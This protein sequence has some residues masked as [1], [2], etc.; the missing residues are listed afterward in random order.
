MFEIRDVPGSRAVAHELD[1]ATLID[2]TWATP[3]FFDAH[4]KGCDI[5]IEASITHLRRHSDLLIGLISANIAWFRKVK[6]ML[7]LFQ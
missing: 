6:A 2:N 7:E 3:L 1:A 5:S 4:S